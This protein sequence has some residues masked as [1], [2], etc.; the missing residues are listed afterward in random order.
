MPTKV[1]ESLAARERQNQE[2]GGILFFF[3][4]QRVFIRVVQKS[5]FCLTLTPIIFIPLIFYLT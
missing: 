4:M 2:E 5:L 1:K 3:L